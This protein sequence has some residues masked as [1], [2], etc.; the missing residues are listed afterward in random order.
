[1]YAAALAMFRAREHGQ[2]VLDFL[3]FLARYPRHP[4]AASAQYWIGEAYFTQRDYRQA[5]VEYEKVLRHGLASPRAADALLRAGQASKALRDSARA[6][7][8][9]RRVVEEYPKSEAAQKART[10]LSGIG[11]ATPSR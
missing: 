9:W 7:Q 10:F 1:M 8:L 4:L 2:A 11:G 6:E 3:D 5:L